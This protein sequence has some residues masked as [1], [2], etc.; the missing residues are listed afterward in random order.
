MVTRPGQAR[1]SLR[2]RGTRVRTARL[3]EVALHVRASRRRA[4]SVRNRVQERRAA[5]FAEHTSDAFQVRANSEQP[6]D[7]RRV[8]DEVTGSDDAAHGLFKISG[9]RFQ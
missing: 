2:R 6:D 1:P 5:A 7:Q 9:N 3:C 8:S 4:L